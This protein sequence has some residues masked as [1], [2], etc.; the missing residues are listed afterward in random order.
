MIMPDFIASIPAGEST[1][2]SYDYVTVDKDGDST[3]NTLSITVQSAD[4]K[5]VITTI[6][7]LSGSFYNYDDSAGNLGTIAL[8]ESVIANQSANASFVSTE[9]D[10]TRASGDLGKGSNLESWLGDDS[11]S[12]KY[13][14]NNKQ[15]TEDSVVKLTG[16]VSLAV[17]SYSIKVTADDGYQIKI[18]GNVVA[19]ID[20]NQSVDTDN[21]T[22]PVTDSGKQSI[23]IIY[24]DQGGDY[25][26]SVFLAESNSDNYQVLGGDAYPTS[27]TATDA[28]EPYTSEDATSNNWSSEDE[29]NAAHTDDLN[30]YGK[31]DGTQNNLDTSDLWEP[32]TIEG[33]D[34]NNTIFSGSDNDVVHGNG[35]NDLISGESGNDTL[36]GGDGND[37]ILGGSQDDI[38]YGEAGDDWL[39]SDSGSNKMYGG[40][41][42]DKLQGGGNEDELYGEE[43]NDLLY[44]NASNDKLFGGSGN[45]YLDGGE[46]D[47]LLDGGDGDDV[48]YGQGGA[49]NLSGGAG[50][51]YLSGGAG[52]DTL[53]GGVGNDYLSGGAGQDSLT[54][55]EGADTFVIDFAESAVDSLTDFNSATDV[56]DIS[57][58]LD[59]PDGTDD[60]ST[61]LN[62]HLSI[63][64]SSV[65]VVENENY[66]KTVA[67]FGNDSAVASGSTVTVIYNDQEYNINIDG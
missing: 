20:S 59:V 5:D 36:Y 1:V 31:V 56:L 14:D 55:G 60:I 67:T 34:D 17:G 16:F 23:E 52:N 7:G 8:A 63:T 38:L 28:N 4:S 44:G 48:L 24:W 64:S 15:S 46:N 10:Y 42:N 11:A 51:D 12:I 27:F 40:S 57:D 37:H 61:Y 3:T 33:N 26:L 54:G 41:G 13:V 58:L 62:E 30:Q 39:Q 65:G 43:G 53:S 50:N 35:G 21:F 49:D 45:D 9:V 66:T 22:F 47:D 25:Q 18:N 6:S 32:N 2:V 19:S 29:L